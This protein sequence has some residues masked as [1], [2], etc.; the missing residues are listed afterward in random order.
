M[1]SRVVLPTAAGSAAGG[2]VTLRQS[3]ARRSSAR[4]AAAVMVVAD[5]AADG[6][7]KASSKNVVIL[8]G[9]IIGCSIAYFLSKRGVSST[10]VERTSIAAAAS[11]K[12]GGFLAGR[13]VTLPGVGLVSRV[14]I[15]SRF[16]CQQTT[17]RKVP[18]LSEMYAKKVP[19]L[20]SGG[21]G[22]GGP[23]QAL[24]RESF[25]LHEQLATE[26]ALE[27]YRKIPT[28]SVAG[29]ANFGDAKMPVSWLDGNVGRFAASLPGF[30]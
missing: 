23:T 29:G 12:A 13:V 4:C 22:D 30:R 10:I 16:D 18:T 3:T 15:G 26:L 8:G 1:S 20:R 21:W 14:S 6:K 24:H 28:L 7:Q 25:K 5:A 27:T 17:L 11:G 2:A 9:G 19:T